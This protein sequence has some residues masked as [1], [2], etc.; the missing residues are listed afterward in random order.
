[1]GYRGILVD[2]I[3]NEFNEDTS[4]SPTEVDKVY[5][6]EEVVRNKYVVRLLLYYLDKMNVTCLSSPSVSFLLSQQLVTHSKNEMYVQVTKEIVS[7]LELNGVE[8]VLM[9]GIALLD[10]LYDGDL[11]QRNMSDIDLF[12]P[13]NTLLFSKD[14]LVKEGFVVIEEREHEIG[15]VRDGVL[16]EL[17]SDFHEGYVPLDPSTHKIDFFGNTIS[18][19]TPEEMLLLLILNFYRDSFGTF[20]F[21]QSDKRVG[22]DI[23]FS[24]LP[25]IAEIRRFVHKKPIDYERLLYL[26]KKCPV[27]HAVFGVLLV[28]KEYFREDIPDE[29]FDHDRRLVRLGDAMKEDSFASCFMLLRRYCIIHES[30]HLL[31]SP[32]LLFRK[33]I[34]FFSRSS[35]RRHYEDT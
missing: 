33:C 23:F 28:I 22:D 6:P 27:P 15:F 17:H 13:S 4:Y 10:T 7:L 5:L 11:D 19:F 24:T 8:C 9:K 34:S 29:F 18:V 14:L 31:K 12:V 25:F 32:L 2:V 21:S 16:V 3:K 26:T 1:M 20:F 30:I 35:L